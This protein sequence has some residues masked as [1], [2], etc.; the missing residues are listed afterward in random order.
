MNNMNKLHIRYFFFFSSRRRHTRLVSDWSS[1]VCSSDLT[2]STTSRTWSSWCA[3][4]SRTIASAC[5]RPPTARRRSPSPRRSR[6]ISCSSTFIFQISAGSRCAARSAPTRVSPA[7]GSSCSRR[8]RSRTTSC[9]DWRPAPTTISPSRSRRCGSC[10]WSIACCRA[11]HG[12]SSRARPRVGLPAPSRGLPAV[13]ALRRGRAP[14]VSPAPARDLPVAPRARQRAGGE[15]PVHARPLRA[16]GGAQPARRVGAGAGVWRRRHGGA[17]GTPARHRQDRRARGHLEEA[18]AALARGVGD[19]ASAS[20]DRRADR[21]ALRVLRRRRPRDPAPSRALGRLRLPRRPRARDHP[22]GGAYRRRRRR[23]RRAHLRALLPSSAHARGGARPARGGGRAHARRDGGGGAPRRARAGGALSVYAI[24]R[25]WEPRPGGL[26]SGA[27]LP[28]LVALGVL[29]A[30][31]GALA[32]AE[33]VPLTPARADAGGPGA[34]ARVRRGR[35]RAHDRGVLPRRAVRS[36]AAPLAVPGRRRARDRALPRPLPRG[37]VAAAQP[38]GHRGRGLLS[39]AAQP[40]QLLALLAQRQHRA[41]RRRRRR[42]LRSVPPAPRRAVTASGRP[43]ALLVAG[44]VVVI[45][46]GLAAADGSPSTPWRHLYLLPVLLAGLRFGVAG[47]LIAA[48]GAV[49]GVGPFVLR[50]I[51][52]HGP[53]RAA[54]EGVV[55]LAVLAGSGALVGSLAARARR[56]RERYETLRAVQRALAEPTPLGRVAARL[57]AVLTRRLGVDAAGL[58]LDE[59]RIVVGAD[60]LD[61][62]SLTARVLARRE[63]EFVTDAGTDARARRVVVVPLASDGETVGALAVERLGDVSREERDA[64]VGFGAAVGLALDN[65]RL[66]ARQRRFAEELEHKVGEAT[67]R[68]GEMDRL[69]S[70]FVALASHELRTPLT[71]LQGFSELLATRAFAPVEVRRLAEIMRGEI[72]RLGR[73]VSDFLDLARLERGLAPAIRRAVLDPAPLIAA[74]VELFP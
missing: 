28:L 8:P 58:V 20:R 7:R 14:P 24:A 4:P 50:E 51:E 62:R 32:R 33:L 41:G 15:G 30:G 31:A 72:E 48:L 56:Q 64:L 63:P 5:S 70:G 40:R 54:A 13:A 35:Q 26:L 43:T 18:G 57:A 59:G 9:A 45:T 68:L 11:S 60:R 46:A 65:A 27:P 52:G 67:A 25:P 36:R 74:A 34:V 71:A 47:G 21:R 69:K 22:P 6:S 19:H 39:H 66:A 12:I 37:S 23:L 38:R 73:I 17:G 61:P 2:S 16:R 3:S 55:T 1:D 42:V 44:L 49:L 29:T 10:R 53:T